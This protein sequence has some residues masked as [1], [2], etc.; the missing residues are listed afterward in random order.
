LYFGSFVRVNVT[1]AVFG[2]VLLHDPPPP[3][4]AEAAIVSRVV[5][6]VVL[7]V[8]LAHVPKV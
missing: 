8:P 3:V 7:A 6:V 4:H 5:A 1:L 2:S